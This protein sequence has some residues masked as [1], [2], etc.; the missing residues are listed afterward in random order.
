MAW[1]SD[2][3]GE[4]APGP[5]YT[6]MFV[7]NNCPL[8]YTTPGFYNTARKACES[9]SCARCWRFTPGNAQRLFLLCALQTEKRGAC[10]PC[11]ARCN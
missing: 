1:H 10:V 5:C 2:T 7:A 4:H 8:R 11:F 9:P 3:I 6:R